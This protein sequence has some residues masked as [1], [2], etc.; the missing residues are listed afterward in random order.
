MPI[1]ATGSERPDARG[2]GPRSRSPEHGFTS[3]RRSTEHG[4][5]LIEL[6]VVITIVALASAVVVL[7]MPAA[8]GSVG[9]EAARFAAR[10][11]AARDAAIIESRDARVDVSSRRYRIEQ[12]SRGAW[13]PVDGRA[14]RAIDWEAGTEV[15]LVGRFAFD[16]TGN[17]RP[18][19]L[20]LRR[21]D[22]LATV[23]VT[24]EGAIRVS[25]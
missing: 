3:L 16:T 17:A 25:P 18:A 11:A 5:T 20:S 1:S 9:R 13:R 14:G 23:A 19:E 8:N 15:A 21:G 10:V 12:R 6:M 22:A 24:D 2:S 4:F 7:A